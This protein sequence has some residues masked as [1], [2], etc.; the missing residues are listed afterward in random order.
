MCIVYTQATFKNNFNKQRSKMK[1]RSS[2]LTG[3]LDRLVLLFTL[4]EKEDRIGFR[5]EVRIYF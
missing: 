5:T 4:T 1:R 3:R 2:L